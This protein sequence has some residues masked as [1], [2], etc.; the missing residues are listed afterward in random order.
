MPFS[1]MYR[2]ITFFSKHWN[3]LKNNLEKS[4]CGPISGTSQLKN[5]KISSYWYDYGH[6]V[7]LCPDQILILHSWQGD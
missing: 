3:E 4:C 6:N 2:V 5:H 1:K 7:M